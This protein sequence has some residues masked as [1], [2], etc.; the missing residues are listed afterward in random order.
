MRWH[1]FGNKEE[2]G[3]AARRPGRGEGTDVKDKLPALLLR[4]ASFEGG[5]GFSALADLEENL[6]VSDVVHVLGIDQARF[7]Y[8]I[9]RIK[10]AVVKKYPKG[11]PI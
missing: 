2:L 4:E 7:D 9:K 6:T 10:R 1:G 5:H 3:L 11:W 8:I